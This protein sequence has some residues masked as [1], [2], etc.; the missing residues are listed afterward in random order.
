[1]SHFAMSCYIVLRDVILRDSCHVILVFTMLY[2]TV[3]ILCAHET[4]DSFQPDDFCHNP[5]P[6]ISTVRGTDGVEGC[7]GLQ[8]LES[9]VQ[10][11][12]FRVQDSPLMTLRSI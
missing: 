12:P 10:D 6:T 11:S 5:I 1:M 7:D 2:S 9:R 3:Y 8:G 4:E